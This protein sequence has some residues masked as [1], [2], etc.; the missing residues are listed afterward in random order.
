MSDVRHSLAEEE[1]DLLPRPYPA[2]AANEMRDL[3]ERFQ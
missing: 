2:C 1:A 3:G